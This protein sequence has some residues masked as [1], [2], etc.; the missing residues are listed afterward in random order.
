MLGHANERVDVVDRVLREAAIGREAVG[1]VPFVELAVVATVVEARGVHPLA[2]ALAA[3]AAGVDLD[4]DALANDK[5]VNRRSE[6]DNRAHVF[7]T[8][9]EVLVE[10]RLAADNAREARG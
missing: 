4:R 6:F 5:F 9:R 2:A 8:G 7:V 1:P 3:T 10:R